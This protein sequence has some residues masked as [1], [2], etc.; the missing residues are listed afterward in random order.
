MEDQHPRTPTYLNGVGGS[1]IS[2]IQG[3]KNIDMFSSFR[4]LCFQN[5]CNAYFHDLGFRSRCQNDTPEVFPKV[6]FR[7]RNTRSHDEFE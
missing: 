7:N 4:K 2:H 6:E 3:S 1:A 5:P